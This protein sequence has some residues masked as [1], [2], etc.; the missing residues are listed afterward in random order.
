MQRCEWGEA[1]TRDAARFV[2]GIFPLADYVR[3]SGK[4]SENRR[5]FLYLTAG[6]LTGA[7]ATVALWPFMHSMNPSGDVLALETVDVD[8]ATIATGQSVT[9]VWQG[10]PV[11]IRRR[12]V[13]EI[14]AAE[15]TSLD[16]LR[17][18]QSDGDRVIKPEWLVLVGVCPHLGCVPRGQRLKAQRGEWNGWLC[19]CH[20]SQFDTSGRIRKGPAPKNLAV[21]TYEFLDNTTI[22]IG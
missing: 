12:T 20:G 14:E 21:P 9:V 5:D 10:K 22:R 4:H 17:D 3:E 15:Q 8:M 19:K 1:V 16:D 18:P 11:F 6:L 2:K 7:G 13:D